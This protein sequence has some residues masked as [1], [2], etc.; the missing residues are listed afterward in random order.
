LFDNLKR[1]TYLATRWF[2]GYKALTENNIEEIIK[3]F[4]Q[5]V[6]SLEGFIPSLMSNSTKKYLDS[7]SIEFSKTGISTE[8]AQRIVITS[9]MYPS[10]NIIDIA[11]KH[12]FDL[13][14]S[15]KIYYAVNDYFNLKWFRG[16]IAEDVS[17][18]YW[19]RLSRLKFRDELDF[20]QKLIATIIINYQ[21]KS[22][23]PNVIIQDWIAQNK[24]TMQRW[25]KIQEMLY[26]SSN[27]NY[28][29]LFIALREL[30]DLFQASD[31][32]DSSSIRS[33]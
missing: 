11:T 28:P 29:M 31:V 26:S 13:L 30:S 5:S 27:L 16:H 7:L 20:V 33:S 21:H 15:L 32:Y 9:A 4:A 10:L 6:K 25:E 12:K 14:K 3:Y 18:D 24:R 19:E 1:F 8:I 23:D 17:E 22:N 2:L